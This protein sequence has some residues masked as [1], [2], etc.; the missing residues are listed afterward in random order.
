[1]KNYLLQVGKCNLEVATL[2][3]LV[4]EKEDTHKD[5]I[6]K[7]RQAEDQIADT[8]EKVTR[9]VSEAEEQQRKLQQVTAAKALSDQELVEAKNRCIVF[10]Y[11]PFFTV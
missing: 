1:M 2:Q 6:E 7:M 5:F 10:F 11:F 3:K 8:E 4:E 9:L